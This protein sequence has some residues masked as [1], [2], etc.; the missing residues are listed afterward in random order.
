MEAWKK[1]KTN[2]SR[3]YNH[4]IN[5]SWVYDRLKNFISLLPCEWN[6]DFKVINITSKQLLFH[7]NEDGVIL[8]INHIINMIYQFLKIEIDFRVSLFATFYTYHVI[9]L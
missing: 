3:N 4:E 6:V 2:E 9:N 1:D 7:L 5:T 8:T